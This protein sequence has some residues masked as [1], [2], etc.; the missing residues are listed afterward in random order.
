MSTI[1]YTRRDFLK[2]VGLG[3]AAL[4]MP[5]R[6][7]AAQQLAGKRGG[8]PNIVF[9]MADDMGYG[10]VGCYNAES[11]IP[12]PNMDHLAKQGIRFTD[13]HTPSAVCSPTRYGLV[14]GRYCW[15]TWLKKRALVGYSRPLI[16]SGR[17][18]VASMLKQHGYKTACIGKWHMGLTWHFKPGMEVDSEAKAESSFDDIIKMGE[19]VDFTRPI[20]DAPVDH[21]F[22][23]FFGTAGCSTTDPPYVFIE[24]NRTLGIPNVMRPDKYM[25]DAGHMVPDWDPTRVDTQFVQKAVEF[26][27][28]NQA[29]PF[30]L[31]LPLSSPHAPWLPPEF[32]K[33]KSGTG[34]RG[35]MVVWV[36]WSVGQI[37]YALDRLNLANNTLVFVTSDNGPRIGV[38]GHKS[39]GKWRGYKSHIWEGG[40]RVPFIVRWPGEIKANT[41]S[42]EVICLT[43]LMA[44]CAA[45]VGANLPDNAGE[46]SYNILPALLGEKLKKPIRPD[47]IH[48]SVWG[49]FSIRQGKWKLI[50]DTQDSG[51]WVRPSDNYPVPGTPGQ[52]YDMEKDPYEKNNLWDKRPEVFGRLTR[53]LEKYKKQCHSRPLHGN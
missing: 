22:D 42:D 35:D 12:T 9:I 16:E 23:Y 44:T 28:G 36:D 29:N 20:K 19:K 2:A 17:M 33:G 50:L 4:A 52:L 21:G 14:T 34:L 8:H 45:I 38:R 26:M 37:L 46:D 11:K 10:D 47:I 32:V 15:R 6:L 43:D 48:H 3:A 27:E 1:D 24:N 7:N 39:A 5:G 41:T 18:T 13:A 30:F 25:C 53:L 40:H 51:G 49:V 31:Y